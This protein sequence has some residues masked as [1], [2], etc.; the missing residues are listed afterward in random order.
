MDNNN[1]TSD[2]INAARIRKAKL[3]DIIA[4]NMMTGGG[5]GSSIRKGISQKFKAR[6]T[7]IREKFDPLNIASAL[8]GRS[9]LGTALAGKVMGRH[10]DEMRYFANKGKGG[11]RTSHFQHENPQMGLAR[12]VSNDESTGKA[13]KK[14][15]NPYYITMSASSTTDVRSGDTLTNVFGKIYNTLRKFH[16]EQIERQEME[17]ENRKLGMLKDEIRH[18]ALMEAIIKGGKQT[19]TPVHKEN[20]MGLFGI[21]GSLFEKLWKILGP[22]VESIVKLAKSFLGK[23]LELG[24]KIVNVLTTALEFLGGSWIAKKLAGMLSGAAKALKIRKPTKTKMKGKDAGKNLK[25]AEAE[26][27]DAAKLTKTVEKTAVKAGEKATEKVAKGVI[28][29]T[30]SKLAKFIP[31]ISLGMGAYF[32]YQR[33]KDGDVQGAILEGMSGLLGAIP[34]PLTLGA[35]VAIDVLLAE[36]D[37]RSKNSVLAKTTDK[38]SRLI[39]TLTG[40]DNYDPNAESK[41]S[42]SA[43]MKNN[44]FRESSKSN[45]STPKLPAGPSVHYT[46]PVSSVP[47]KSSLMNAT[48]ENAD[49]NLD[50]QMGG[51]NKPIVINK[52]N[53][54]PMPNETEDGGM[55][56]GVASVRDEDLM[57]ILSKN[58]SRAMIM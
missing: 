31:G 9:K 19:A 8:V 13:R 48:A 32:S 47:D 14:K 29:A 3:S 7:G 33:A 10:G 42:H 37:A 22:I 57:G 21:L 20:E 40:S 16:G 5:I 28:K 38:A 12:A 55:E 30:S 56:S 50:Q 45:S 54:I 44:N 52:N 17:D 53:T 6:A 27:K 26:A 4:E 25:L 2:Y 1:K 49:L 35:A 43:V 39:D 34:F 15:K 41:P 24:A 36:R 23:I 11:N 58:S 18:A 46:N 51:S